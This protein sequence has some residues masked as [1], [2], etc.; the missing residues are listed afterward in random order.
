MPVRI[1]EVDDCYEATIDMKYSTDEGWYNAVDFNSIMA[2]WMKNLLAVYATL[3]GNTTGSIQ[4]TV[5][6]AARERLYR[7]HSCLVAYKEMLNEFSS[8]LDST[9]TLQ[10]ATSQMYSDVTVSI[11]LMNYFVRSGNILKANLSR[12]L[13]G[14]VSTVELAQAFNVYNNELLTVANS[15]VSDVQASVIDKILEM[16]DSRQSV[17]TDV[18]QELFKKY[19]RL[20]SFMASNDT[21]V[22]TTARYHSIWRV[23]VIN[24]QN[25]QVSMGVHQTFLVIT[26]SCNGHT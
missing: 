25:E 16:V 11:E 7:L 21:S 24:L 6:T 19:E 8:W 17:L 15:F 14:D 23:P 10:L 3:V 13:E 20:S 12:Y 2:N 5:W 26:D 1:F 22:E 18:Y 9:S 4:L